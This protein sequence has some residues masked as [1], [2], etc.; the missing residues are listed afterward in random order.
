MGPDYLSEDAAITLGTLIVPMHA[1]D[2]QDQGIQI[3]RYLRVR[4]QVALAQPLMMGFYLKLNNGVDIWIQ[5][6]Y[7][8]IFRICRKCGCVGRIQRDCS[9]EKVEIQ[10]TI[11][12]HKQSIQQRHN[13]PA[14]VNFSYPLFVSE[15]AAFCDSRKR[16]TT[17]FSFSHFSVN[18]PIYTM[19]DHNLLSFRRT[20]RYP[21]HPQLK[22]T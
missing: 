3:L 13:C 15:P 7:E 21:D 5:F 10:A 18:G 2:F 8:R 9:K 17:R 20:G 19:H 11:D 6:P 4:V 12:V 1:V 14:L 22:I 16:R